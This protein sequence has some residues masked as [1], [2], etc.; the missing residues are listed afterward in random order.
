MIIVGPA[1]PLENLPGRDLSAGEERFLRF[2]N[3][4]RNEVVAEQVKPHLAAA[5]ESCISNGYV[6]FDGSKYSTTKL[7][8]QKLSRVPAPPIIDL[9]AMKEYVAWHGENHALDF[10]TQHDIAVAW[11]QQR[12]HRY[13]QKTWTEVES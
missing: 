13:D 7:G 10:W 12:D 4:F 8:R 9:V 6:I 2:M 1:L 11:A 3:C 5:G